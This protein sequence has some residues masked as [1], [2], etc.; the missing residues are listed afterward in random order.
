MKKL[1]TP[2][3]L[4]CIISCFLIKPVKAQDISSDPGAYM[5]AIGK[6]ETNMNK[7]YMAYISAAAHS[8]RKRKIEK[9]RDQAVE[10]I[11]TCQTTIN[12]LPAFKGDNSLRQSSLTFVQLCYKIFNDDY[13]HIVNMED[14]AERS[15]D[16]M[17]AYLLLQ[18]A[19]NDT[20]KVGNERMSK[21][22]KNFAAKYNITLIDQKS[23]L[24]DKMEATDRVTKYYD[25][26]YLLFYKCNWE[27]NQLTEAV[28]QKNVTKI[29]QVRSALYKYAIEGLRVLD[30][31]H[32]FDNDGSLKE[33]CRQ[34][35]AFYKDEAEKQIPIY[36]DFF[37]KEENFTRFKATMD[38]K[39]ESQR[40]QKD[41]D[42]YNKAV[43]D[44]N[45]AVNTYNQVNS[46]LNNGRVNVN[47]GWDATEKQFLDYHTPYYKM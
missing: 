10:S 27:E 43:S 31:L 39:P 45:N 6:A 17:Q 14:I 41:V 18:E 5:D 3:I 26:V 28:N 16:E 15:Y 40:T 30:T 46:D 1:F 20:L 4:S 47:N 25:K 38:A 23:E 32:S 44:I 19:T 2:V 34:A 36:T 8:G 11:L 33:S 12:Y 9:M 7:A 42:T 37:L 29:E 13:A 21:A 22:Q 24:S 35:L